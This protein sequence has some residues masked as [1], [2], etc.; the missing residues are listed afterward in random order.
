MITAS[1]VSERHRSF[2]SWKQPINIVETRTVR[3]G[4]LRVCAHACK[5]SPIFIVV[6]G[7]ATDTNI[8]Y[9]LGRT[10]NGNQCWLLFWPTGHKFKRRFETIYPNLFSHRLLIDQI[11]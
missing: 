3:G 5:L 6:D 10:F 1:T 7:F 8:G 4:E 11:L 2:R 9:N